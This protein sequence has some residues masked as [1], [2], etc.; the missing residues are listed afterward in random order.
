M[1]PTKTLAL[2][3]MGLFLLPLI[4]ACASR[5]VVKPEVVT[6]NTPVYVK[7]PAE[8]TTGVSL[9]AFPSRPLVNSDLADFVP[10]CRGVVDR[11]NWQ[12]E[13]IRDAEAKAGAQ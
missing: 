2:G 4:G 12:L 13:H 7:M 5:Q 10:V 1:T 9:P 11:A 6:V 8:Y 3:L